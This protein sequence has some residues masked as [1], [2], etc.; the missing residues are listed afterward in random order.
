VKG[1]KGKDESYPLSYT[2]EP[3]ERLHRLREPSKGE[4]YYI[5]GKKI[6]ISDEE[7]IG[8]MKNYEKKIGLKPMKTFQLH[9]RMF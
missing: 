8:L 4:L 1:S 9:K 5:K 2:P 6:S 7:Y 3:E